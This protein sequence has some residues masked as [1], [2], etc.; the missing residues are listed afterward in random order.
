MKTKTKKTK[1]LPVIDLEVLEELLIAYNI[2]PN[3]YVPYIDADNQPYRPYWFCFVPREIEEHVLGVYWEKDYEVSIS[4]TSFIYGLD[5]LGVYYEEYLYFKENKDKPNFDIK[6]C[7][8]IGDK[9]NI[10]YY[11]DLWD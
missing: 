7:K 9:K 5:I 6:E 1:E 8:K 2:A 10:N 4:Y 11:F 3:R